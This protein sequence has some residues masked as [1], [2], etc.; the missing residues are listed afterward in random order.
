M[1]TCPFCT[2]PQE[3]IKRQNDLGQVIRDGYPISPGHTL[4]IPKRHIASFFQLQKHEH[5]ALLRLIEEA[6]L[7]LDEEFKPDAYNIGINDGPVAGQ[8]VPHLHIHLIPR[9]QGDQDDPR[10]GVRWI[11]PE[12]A[13]YWTA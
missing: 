3:R 10:G 1:T 5:D 12:K 8:T 6:K 9:Y 13:K 7:D 11:I 2:L 4:I